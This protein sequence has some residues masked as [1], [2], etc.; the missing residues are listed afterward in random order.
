[1]GAF[2]SIF[3][4]TKDIFNQGTQ[5]IGEFLSLLPE[6]STGSQQSEARGTDTTHENMPMCSRRITTTAEEV[7]RDQILAAAEEFERQLTV[8]AP[9]LPPH[10]QREVSS[11][12]PRAGQVVNT[13]DN[14]V[15]G[16]RRRYRK[17]GPLMLL[18]KSKI[19]LV[20]HSLVLLCSML[21]IVTSWMLH[22]DESNVDEGFMIANGAS[23]GEERS[24]H[25]SVM[26]GSIDSSIVSEGPEYAMMED[27][28]IEHEFHPQASVGSEFLSSLDEALN[29]NVGK[30][31]IGKMNI[32]SGSMHVRTLNVDDITKEI[33]KTVEAFDGY[34]ESSSYGSSNASFETRIPSYSFFDFL[35]E[36]IAIAGKEFVTFHTT[37]K[38][39]TKAY[40]EAV[41]RTET[42]DATYKALRKLL[43]RAT[44][45]NEILQ[46]NR[47]I[48]NLTS[49]IETAKRQALTIKEHEVTFDQTE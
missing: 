18:Q 27:V 32:Y 35:E 42:L 40:V 44:S 7:E 10:G 4:L 16:N 17:G 21:A 41:T 45:V 49:K 28:P 38:D 43:E 1:M 11:P 37:V 5:G 2:Q 13:V 24:M 25:S 29:I 23:K 12:D 46:I 26:T 19:M 33:R 15:V 8:N 36:I 6:E 3:N 31:S 20:R 39:K 22:V 14:Q 48:D 47:E 9:P 34:I 30:G